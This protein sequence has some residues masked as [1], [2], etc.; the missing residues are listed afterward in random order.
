[1]F[2]LE[3]KPDV[4]L[5]ELEKALCSG[6]V[7]ELLSSDDNKMNIPDAYTLVN[8][9]IEQ[10][11]KLEL[12]DMGKSILLKLSVKKKE[13][14]PEHNLSSFYRDRYATLVKL[15]K[16]D[17]VYISKIEGNNIYKIG[18]VHEG[19]EASVYELN[20]V[21]RPSDLVFYKIGMN[22]IQYGQ[23]HFS[24]VTDRRSALDLLD[25]CD[26]NEY[27]ANQLAFFK[28]LLN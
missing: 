14:F 21:V 16:C 18:F 22:A 5:T 28:Y 3:E 10:R 12:F 15:K 6:A 23:R 7:N 20:H 11:K 27:P 8:M 25:K 24:L 13:T 4:L 2:K 9:T 19:N 26:E 17:L 1:M